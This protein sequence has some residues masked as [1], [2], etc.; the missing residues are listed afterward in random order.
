MEKVTEFLKKNWIW[1]LIIVVVIVY[2]LNRKKKE[3]S[4]RASMAST[5]PILSKIKCPPG[6]KP[7]LGICWCLAPQDAVPVIKQ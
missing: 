6:C 4:Y 5:G 7:F 1:V 3:S 2:L